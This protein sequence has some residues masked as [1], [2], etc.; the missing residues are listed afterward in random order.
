MEALALAGAVVALAAKILA[1]TRVHKWRRLAT[2]EEK[3]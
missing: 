1:C 3:A 2:T